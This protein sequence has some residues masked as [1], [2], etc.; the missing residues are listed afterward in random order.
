MTSSCGRIARRN[1]PGAPARTRQRAP[2]AR[3]PHTS[4]HP[5]GSRSPWPTG[6]RPGDLPLQPNCMSHGLRD[7][8]PLVA[9]STNRGD[10]LRQPKRMR[11]RCPST[12]SARGTQQ[13]ANAP[14]EQLR[15]MSRHPR[16]S[17]VP[18]RISHQS[19]VPKPSYR[20][21]NPR[22]VSRRAALQAVTQLRHRGIPRGDDAG[23]RGHASLQPLETSAKK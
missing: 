8:P 20:R 1:I 18:W 19:S 7:T 2:R 17:R 10:R 23:D 12:R 11:F 21:A 3:P 22:A 4:A 13:R 14:H 9:T 5:R 16:D 15:P 6:E